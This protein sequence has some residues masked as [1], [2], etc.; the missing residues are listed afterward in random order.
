MHVLVLAHT[1]IASDE[2]LIKPVNSIYHL[3]D[4]HIVTALELRFAVCL[5]VSLSID[6]LLCGLGV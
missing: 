2:L 5:A 1:S 6:Q 4:A 3:C